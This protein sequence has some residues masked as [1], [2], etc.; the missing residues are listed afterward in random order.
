MLRRKF[1]EII[2]DN[3][4]KVLQAFYETLAIRLVNSFG[5]YLQHIFFKALCAYVY[6]YVVFM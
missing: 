3:I 2:L 6:L 4:S 1:E 5:F